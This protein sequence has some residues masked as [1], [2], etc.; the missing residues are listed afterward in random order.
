MYS[1]YAMWESNVLV[2]S[3]NIYRLEHTGNG[4]DGLYMVKFPTTDETFYYVWDA[5]TV[6][7]YDKYE[8]AYKDYRHWHEW[9]GMI[10]KE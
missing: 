4:N 1:N 5:D 3:G 8:D 10:G 9:L 7:V 2:R 6:I